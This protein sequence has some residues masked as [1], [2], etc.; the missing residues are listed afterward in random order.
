MS[1]VQTLSHGLGGFADLRHWH[2]TL[3]ARSYGHALLAAARADERIVCLGA[4]L[5]QPTQTHLFRD[6]L[7]DR[8]FML[9]IQEANMVGVAGGMAR[10]GDIPFAHSFCVFITRRVFDQI[11]MQAAYPKLPVKLVGFM[12]GL[13]TEL[14]VSHQAI[15]DIA[16]MRSLPNMAVIE[17]AGPAQ[18]G[19]AVAAALDY[20]GPVYLRLETSWAEPDESE[21]LMPLT[22]GKGQVLREGEDV[23]ILASGL[24]V[25]QAL[26][27]ANMLAEGGVSAS[28]VNMA[29]IKP[30]DRDLVIRLAR[31]HKAM[32]TAENHSIVGG[33]GAAVAETLAIGGIG[34]SFAMIG[35]Q[36]VFAEGA[37]LDYLLDKH[38][39]NA[40]HIASKARQLLCG[41]G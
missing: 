28:V 26:Q 11:A 37:S 22:L 21:P 17:P 20:D 24:M 14:G 12:P 33:L 36:D 23:A 29:S 2:E 39:M 19:A 25:A 15:D 9:G 40:S 31:S 8:F 38:K 3:N 10:T 7:P 13:T 34:L 5:S 1:E 4:D 30:L 32:L 16:L 6:A 41:M 27:A 35:I 18:I